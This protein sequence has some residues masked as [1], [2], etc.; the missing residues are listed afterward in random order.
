[1]AVGGLRSSGETQPALQLA[2]ALYRF[3]YLHGHFAEGHAR[4]ERLLTTD[5]RPTAARARALNGAAVMMISTADPAAARSRSEEALA[6]HRE[7][8][9]E[10]GIAYSIFSLGMD[11]TEEA[12][13]ARARPYLEE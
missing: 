12:D 3:W 1:A 6:L 5:D 10:W 8:G 13:W 2:G 11:A 9:D 7:L 4:L